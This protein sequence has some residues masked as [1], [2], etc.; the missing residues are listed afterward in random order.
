MY[1][2][3]DN[4]Q[5]DQAPPTGGSKDFHFIAYP[6]HIL[7]WV[8][9]EDGLCSFVSPSWTAF[10]GR[11]RT[12]ELGKG[13]LDRVHPDDCATLL[14]GL[15]TARL[16]QQPF[17]LTF[18]YLREDGAYRWLVSQGMPHTTSTDEFVGHISLCFDVTPYQEGEAEIENSVQNIFP[19]LKQTRLIAAILDTHGRIQFLNSGLCRLLKCGG[20]ELMNCKLF[21]RYLAANDRPLLEALYPEGHQ[22]A[23]FPAEFQSQLLS[24]WKQVRH[25][26]WHA[27]TWREYS[28]RVKGTILIGDDVTALLREEEQ[29]SLFSK[30]FEATDH[31]IVVTD[32]DGTI[33]SINRAFTD[34]T[35]YSREEAIGSNPRILQSGRHDEA[36]YERLWASLRAT[37]HWHGDIWDRHKDGSIYPKYLSISAIKNSSNELT[38]FVGIFYDNSE[39][40]TVEERLKRLAHYDTLTGLPNRSLLFDRLEQALER[41]TRLGTSVGLL[42]L[43]L[44]DFKLV[45]DLHGHLAGDEVLKAAAQRMKTCVRTRDTIARLG[46]DEFVVLVPDTSGADDLAVVAQKLLEALSPPYEIEGHIVASPPSI[47]ISIFPDNGSSA[48]ELMKCADVAMYQ[49]KRCGQGNFRF[50][51]NSTITQK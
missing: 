32:T 20:N 14:R 12:E 9:N 47:G 38:N 33:V 18:R 11:A 24:N 30:A 3:S 31:A 45:N 40:F 48:E 6:N 36:F 23:I 49:A 25:V 2:S 35:G 15:D 37:D 42:Y 1:M 5:A 29:T 43:D 50:F 39:R 28:G 27:I 46:G 4:S 8:S 34:L 7:V 26:S 51:G 22:N 19:L 16:S 44:D 21:E 10:T 13:W 41:A 17:R